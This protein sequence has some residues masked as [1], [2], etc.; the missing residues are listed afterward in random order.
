MKYMAFK[1]Y[2]VYKFYDFISIY[3]HVY[4][5]IILLFFDLDVLRQGELRKL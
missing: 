3:S 2:N 4:Y 1:M 5:K